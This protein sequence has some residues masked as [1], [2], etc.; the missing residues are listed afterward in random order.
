MTDQTITPEEYEKFTSTN[1]REIL[2]YLHQ[3]INDGERISIV[4]NEGQDAL[5]S[6]LLDVNEENNQLIF[7]WG[8]SEET[9]R[10]L[11]HS[12]R[13]FFVCAPHGVANKFMT[14]KVS[15]ITHKK[16]PAFVTH[17]PSQYTRLQRREFFRLVLPL[18]RRPT[19]TLT[20][21]DGVTMQLSIIDISIGGIAAELPGGKLS[22]DIGRTLPRARI[23]LKGVG[24][25][26][27]D[28]EV[29]NSSE[30]QRGGKVSGRIGCR[31]VKLSHAMENQLQRFI[32]DVQREERARLGS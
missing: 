15:Q 4:F 24:M 16:R 6:L 13:N 28:L 32:T 11:L 25:L 30:I 10:K 5:L 14:G 9:N 7:D 31:F 21:A 18:T 20:M 27:I 22:F 17:I 12:E 2:F 3:L 26:D 29:R 19:C 23:D 1:R 8:G